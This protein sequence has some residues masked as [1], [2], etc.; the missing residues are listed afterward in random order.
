MHKET[1]ADILHFHGFLM[2]SI[3]E[4]YYTQKIFHKSQDT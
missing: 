2:Y 4:I 3:I 1:S